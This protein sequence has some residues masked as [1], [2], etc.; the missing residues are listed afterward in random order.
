MSLIPIECIKS[1]DERKICIAFENGKMYK[2]KNNSSYKIRK[3][4]IDNCIDRHEEKRCDYL[5][6]IESIYRVI[7]IELKGGDLAH[8]LKQIYNTILYLKSEFKNYQIDARIVGSRDVP[9]FI[10]LPD[11]LRLEREIRKFKGQII[12]GTN[13]IYIENI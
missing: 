12:R 10:G 8:A 13:N 1:Y 3:V 7:F 2:L 4:K 11:Y 5:M 6:E 9:G